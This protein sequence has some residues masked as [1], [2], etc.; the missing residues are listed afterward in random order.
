MDIP[1]TV[2]RA[3]Q[4]RGNELG[5]IDGA[6]QL[7]WNQLGDRIAR[8]GGFFGSLG[9]KA[10]DRVVVVSQSSQQYI[11]A[12]F[13]APWIGAAIV[14][15]NVR[16]SEV[17]L[18]KLLLSAAPKVI[19]FDACYASL[20]LG[21]AKA[22]PETKLVYVTSASQPDGIEEHYSLDNNYFDYED[23]IQNSKP[24]AASGCDGD[25][26]AAIFYTGGTTGDA[27]GVMLSHHNILFNALATIPYL[28]TSNRTVQLH[29]GPLF[30]TG[31]GQRVFTATVAA[32]THVVLPKFSPSAFCQA[33]EE[34]RATA[35]MLVPTMLQ[36]ILDFPDRE[37]YDLSSLR[38]ISY[39]GAPMPTRLLERLMAS[40]NWCHFSHSYGMTELSPV[41][42]AL[43]DREHRTSRLD[44]PKLGSIGRSAL[45]TE[46]IIA[47]GDGIEVARGQAGEIIVRGPNV[48]LGYWRRP[49]LTSEVLKNGWMHTGDIGVMDD[50]G[51]VTLLDRKKDMII[52]GGENVFSAEVEEILQ[53]MESVDKC[54][55][56]GLPDPKWGERVHAVI[57]SKDAVAPTL[58]DLQDH[59]RLFLAA[60]KIPRSYTVD[61]EELPLS[62]ANKIDKKQLRQLLA[63]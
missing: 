55:V 18:S 16:L 48:M 33:V 47:D 39:G 40:L 10:G 8:L 24:V 50:A 29:A 61:L 6:T 20:V 57:I 38:H 36:M 53:R 45:T 7:T 15:A 25:D 2:R 11:E 23:G 31:A 34:H 56:V 4:H 42:T 54:A 1:Q 9:T 30:H 41:A 17:E 44:G 51:Y 5:L 19:I 12:Y 63:P 59:C 27:K 3:M 49:D 52:S 32:A 21:A 62:A 14:P 46:V 58:Q 37:K 35:V 28:K 60:Y 22:V 43:T 13:A 26:M